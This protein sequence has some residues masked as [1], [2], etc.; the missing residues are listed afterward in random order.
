MLLFAALASLVLITAACADDSDQSDGD[1]SNESAQLEGTSEVP[2]ECEMSEDDEAVA[3]ATAVAEERGAPDAALAEGVEIGTLEVIEEA[4]GEAVI[5]GGTIQAQWTFMNPADGEVFQ[6]TWDADVG[7]QPIPL[8]QFPES[9]NE[10]AAGM[11]VGGRYAIAISVADAGGAPP[12]LGLA[13]EDPVVFILDVVGVSDASSESPEVDPDALAAAEERGAP[14][15]VI[16]DGTED[17]EELVVIDDVVGDGEVLCPGGQVIA[18]YTGIQTSDGEE[19][20]S[21]WERGEPSPFGLEQVIPGWTEGLV[22][23]KVGGRRTL[24]IPTSMAYD[25]QEGKPEGVLMFTVDL[26]GAG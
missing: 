26:V 7:A 22:G 6:S 2:E 4:D 1:S 16:P 9:F 8:S 15:M 3:E 23:M 11:K 10:A 13:D 24:V 17:T 14:E 19:F 18:H 5:P 21:S 12:E 20:D 25:G